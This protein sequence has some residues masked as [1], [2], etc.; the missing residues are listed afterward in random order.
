MGVSM[1]RDETH[2]LDAPA[3]DPSEDRLLA[4]I[5]IPTY[6]EVDN[7]GILLDRIDKAMCSQGLS[8][9]A[10][11]V[12]D[13][14]DDGTWRLVAER[15][16]TDER[17]RLIHR[18]EDRG[19]SSAVLAGM[20]AANGDV[21][22]VI[23][24]DLQHDEQRLPDLIDAVRQGADVSL[25]SREVTGGSYGDFA[26]S[27]RWASQAA[28]ALA[29]WLIGVSVSD[30]MSGFFAV[31]RARHDEVAAE[32]NPR[33]FKILLEFVA[34]GSSPTVTEVG[35]RFGER[36]HGQTKLNSAVIAAYLVGVVELAFNARLSRLRRRR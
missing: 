34:R 1:S 25:G 2:V 36:M 14:S 16:Q 4:S 26:L 33:G 23:D 9:E 21:L 20:A 29:R 7:I 32:I 19:L 5:V 30:P 28:A 12:D 15:G 27:R 18:T 22:A 35:Y 31:S 3:P 8:Y 24:A 10:I 6:N 17:V 11:V 13:D